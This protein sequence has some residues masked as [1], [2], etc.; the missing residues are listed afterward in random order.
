[1]GTMN[2]RREGTVAILTMDNGE[3]RHNPEFIKD[4]LEHMDAIEADPE[5]NAVVIASADPKNWS[6]G[7]DLQWIV[8]AMSDPV[9]HDEVRD[10][11]HGLNR[12]FTRCLTYP[13]PVIAAIAGHAFGD[14]AILASACD[15]RFMMSDRGFFCFPEVDLNIPFLPGMIAVIEKA[16]PQPKLDELTLTGKKAGGAELAEAGVVVKAVEGA[17]ET[18]AA[19]VEFAGQ[20][21]KGREVVRAIKSR[22]YTSVI[23]VFEE[24]D[25]PVIQKLQ[26]MV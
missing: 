26:L 5:A 25:P 14:G 9:R 22:R 13:M 7:I 21:N 20:F 1:M 8:G 11:L 19:A 15:F 17:E 23:K 18:L 10:F 24:L 12:M 3:N 6:Q 2:V 16:V 4:F